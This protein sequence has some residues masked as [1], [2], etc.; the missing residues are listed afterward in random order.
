MDK[1]IIKALNQQVMVELDSSYLYI[2][3]AG[4]FDSRELKGFANWLRKQAHEEVGHALILFNCLLDN[5]ADVS[6]GRIDPERHTFS[7]VRDA[8]AMLLLR[9]KFI[10]S[11]VN[12]LLDLAQ[13][14]DDDDTRLLLTWLSAVQLEEEAAV[15]AIIERIN[16]ANASS[17]SG[18]GP[19]LRE[20]DAELASREF[21]T[22]ELL[23]H[24]RSNRFIAG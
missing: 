15:L 20:L 21:T 16:I 12:K 7:S 9:G 4:W 6:L 8:I 3:M 1:S 24:H 10:A 2:Q 5:D 13:E 11:W 14:A 22:P 19:E 18:C 23:K 17:R